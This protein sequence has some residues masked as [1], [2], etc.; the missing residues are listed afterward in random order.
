MANPE[1]FAYLYVYDNKIGTFGDSKESLE[2]MEILNN[3]KVHADSFK[4]KK[5]SAGDSCIHIRLTLNPDDQSEDWTKY[6]SPIME[7][8]MG[9]NIVGYW[10]VNMVDMYPNK[11]HLRIVYPTFTIKCE[12][13][14]ISQIEDTNTIEEP[15]EVQE[16]IMDETIETTTEEQ[17]T[18]AVVE[19]S[20][21][22]LPKW[23][24]FALAGA[25]VAAVA[26]AVTAVILKSKKD[27][28]D[29]CCC[30]E[31]VVE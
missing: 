24:K 30:C 1:Y 13:R 5:L 8:G 3:T 6:G 12:V 25:G 9:G 4:K 21:K 7:N 2:A 10:P 20:T 26:T 18:E 28:D 19:K 27:K 29:N 31:E 23:A 14:Y 22:K 11:Q 15:K 16:N 17:T